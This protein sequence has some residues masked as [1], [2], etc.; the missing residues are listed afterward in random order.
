MIV[1][2]SICGHLDFVNF[3][4]GGKITTDVETHDVR[5]QVETGS[6]ALQGVI[7]VYFF[8]SG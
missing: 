5:P 1:Y 7:I 6:F 3:D 4:D 8:I 2:F